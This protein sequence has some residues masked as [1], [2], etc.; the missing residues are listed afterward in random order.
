MLHARLVRKIPTMPIL[1][2]KIETCF[3]HIKVPV[4][5]GA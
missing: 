4:A 1:K 3:Q 2:L 5:Y